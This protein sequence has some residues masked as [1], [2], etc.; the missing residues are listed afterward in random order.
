MKRLLFLIPLL[1]LGCSLKGPMGLQG[2]KGEPGEPGEMGY[3]L[4]DVS[5]TDKDYKIDYDYSYVDVEIPV[6]KESVVMVYEIDESTTPLPYT[7]TQDIDQDGLIDWSL[8]KTFKI[9][10]GKVRLETIILMT[11]ANRHFLN[12]KFKIVV[13]E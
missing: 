5:L 6:S 3:K 13:F 12:C 2:V 1:F 10:D 7:L 4:Y 11:T 9:L 8:I